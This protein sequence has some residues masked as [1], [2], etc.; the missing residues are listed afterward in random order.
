[1]MSNYY[2]SQALKDA[3]IAHWQNGLSYSKIVKKIND[4]GIAKISK[5]TVGDLVAKFRKTNSTENLPRSGRPRTVRTPQRINSTQMKA[6]R[7]HKRSMSQLARDANINKHF[8][9]PSS[10]DLNVMDF[11]IWGILASRACQKPHSN[12]DSLKCSLIKEWNDIDPEIIRACSKNAHKR[13][14]AVVRANG[15][16]IEQN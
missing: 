6:H 7:N 15:G 2:H 9:P 13:L 8:W 14:E 12:L 5:G 4:S 11:S 3:I 10:P 16:Y 1:M